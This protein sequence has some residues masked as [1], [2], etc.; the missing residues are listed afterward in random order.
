MSTPQKV[1]VILNN[2]NDWDEWIEV[3]KVHAL[4]GEVWDHV[5]PSKETVP[6]LV[7]P[8]LPDSTDVNPA[9]AT[10][11]QLSAEEKD[12]YKILRQ[13]YKLDLDRYNRKRNALASLCSH[14]QSTVSRTCLFYTYGQ[15]TARE[16]LLELQKRL[17]PTDQLR[18][19]ELSRRYAKLKKTPKNQDLTEWLY[20]WE[21]V[22]HEC[23]KINLP[24]V[25]QGR[26]VR[27]FL[28]AIAPITP[29]F[30]AI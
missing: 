25:Q 2:S 28:T 8:T 7:E 23:H 21:K 20:T 9:A 3:V 6:A 19:L 10:Y 1:S 11:G 4:S 15:T 17:K 27:D 5:D 14:I 26:A 24:D 16:M 22:Y 12:N 29:E 13:N 30:A 18:E